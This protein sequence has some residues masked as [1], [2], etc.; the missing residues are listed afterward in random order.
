M[1]KNKLKI[2][3]PLN[4]NLKSK[5]LYIWHF[6]A[7]S[8]VKTQKREFRSYA[9]NSGLPQIRDNIFL[10]NG[11]IKLNYYTI[12]RPKLVAN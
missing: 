2:E 12:I 9:T 7:P 8:K 6:F 5:F 3:F 11:Q 1:L 4:L 10:K